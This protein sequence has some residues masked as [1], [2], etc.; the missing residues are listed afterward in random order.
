[1]GSLLSIALS[2]G[3]NLAGLGREGALAAAFTAGPGNPAAGAP[4]VFTDASGG[5]PTWWQ[6]DFGDGATS[7]RPQESHVFA[8]PGTYSVRLT[9]GDGSTQATVTQLVS[10]SPPGT[11]RLLAAHGF[12]V[13]LEARD[14][15]GRSAFGQAVPQDDRFGYFTVPDLAQSPGL[16]A[17]EV[18]VKI[19]DETANGQNYFVYWGGLT[20][21]EYTMTVVET[22]TGVS[23]AYHNLATDDPACLGAD[24]SGFSAT[25]A[26]TPT[27]TRIPTVH[28]TP[29]PTPTPTRTSAGPTPTR[30][31]TTTPTGVAPTP[32]ATLTGTPTPSPTPTPTPGPVVV[33]LRAVY[34]QWDFVQGPETSQTAPYPGV[35]TIT[36]HKG[37]TYEFHIYNDGP[38]LDPPLNP[39]SFSGV[40]AIGLNGCELDTG[41]ADVIQTITPTTTGNFP[42]NCTF[43][44]C[45]TGANQHD[46]MHGVIK[47]VP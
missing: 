18:F 26:P 20:D 42:F 28:G 13:T 21:L 47:V 23:K 25:P 38:V 15:T 19:L 3:L 41:A 6:W 29:T 35:N 16:P 34:W 2:I 36:L 45:G 22:A 46:A 14:G 43:T 9:C 8:A 32:T 11:L 33:K 37:V 5:A 12:D 27:K 10:V 7:D 1:V 4:V 31:P 44:D 24:T 17:P 40:A 30:T 39:H